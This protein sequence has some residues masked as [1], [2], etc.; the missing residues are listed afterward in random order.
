MPHYFLRLP[1][2]LGCLLILPTAALQAQSPSA[3][4]D[5]DN[6]Y[7][8]EEVVVTARKTEQKLSEIPISATVLSGDDLVDRQFLG[9]A[10]IAQQVPNLQFKQAFSNTLPAIYIRGVGNSDF[11]VNANGSVSMYADEVFLNSPI[12]QG[13]QLFD[14]ERVEVLRGPQGTLYG[15]NTTGG[16]INFVSRKPS[17]QR[18]GYARLRLGRYD[19]LR[20]EGAYETPIGEDR[21]ALR[22]AVAGNQSDGYVENTFNGEDENAL[23][24]FSARLF[25]DIN[26]GENW[27]VLLGVNLFRNRADSIRYESRGLID[28][29]D[30]LGYVESPDPFSGAWNFPTGEE[31]DTLTTSLKLTHHGDGWQFVSITALGNAERFWLEDV[32]ASPNRLLETTWDAE[33]DQVSQEFRIQSDGNGGTTWIAGVYFFDETL[34]NDIRNDL[35]GILREQGLPFDPVNGPFNL[36]QVFRQDSTSYAVFGEATGTL[37]PRWSWTLGLRLTRDEKEFLSNTFI[38]EDDLIIPLIDNEFRAIS[39]DEFSGK[40]GLVFKPNA[41]TNAYLTLSRGFRGGGFK[42]GAAFLPEEVEPV[43]PET[44]NALEIGV[45]TTNPGRSIG[46][47]ASAFVYDYQDLQVFN[48]VNVGSIPTQVLDNA[49]DARIYGLEAELAMR[50]TVGWDLRFGLGLLDTEYRD[51]VLGTGEDFSGNQLIMSPETTFNSQITYWF[52]T[53]QRGL[54]SVR[55]DAVFMDAVFFDSANSSGLTADDYWLLNAAVAYTSAGGKF[56][57]ALVAKNLTDEL[58]IRD[59]VDLSA[60]GFHEVIYGEPLTYGAE[61]SARF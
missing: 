58:Y 39:D 30:I 13:F 44:L 25:L 49:S 34:D 15:K 17:Y 42:G 7:I 18:G 37:N 47:N 41:R 61:F 16:A 51:F 20:F 5:E 26:A 54:F 52:Q 59:I 10:E 31:V 22:V 57:I 28:G 8:L 29:A 40:A 11:N 9:S 32:D 48:T 27:D 14:L 46:L 33:A 36:A 43:N 23:D 35:L 60:F 19:H 6:G 21:A 50:P 24:D 1:C 45:K 2:L 53:Q 56:G 4:E 12:S 55:A 3:T 38:F